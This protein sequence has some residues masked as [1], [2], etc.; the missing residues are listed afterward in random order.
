MIE[1][2][3]YVFFPLFSLALVISLLPSYSHKFPNFSF[4]SLLKAIV[5]LAF[6][7][8]PIFTRHFILSLVFTKI[9]EWTLFVL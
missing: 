7:H 4:A 1:S 5:F 3:Y 2:I 6:K 9:E 8:Q